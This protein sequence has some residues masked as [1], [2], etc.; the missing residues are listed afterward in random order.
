[1][2]RKYSSIKY[3]SMIFSPAVAA[4]LIPLIFLGMFYFYPV[5]AILIKSFVIASKF[6]MES[7]LIVFESKRILKIIGFTFWQAGLSTLI[8]LVIGLP[9]A[10]VFASYDFKFKKAL[11]ILSTIPFVLP[12]V[13]VAAAFQTLIGENGFIHS[14][15]FE[16]PVLMILMAH[17][18]FN[19]SVVLRIVST[20]WGQ[21]NRQ[22]YDAASILGASPVKIF[23]YITLPMLRPALMAC[24]ILV[25]IFCFCSFGVIMILGGPYYSTME[26][27]IYRQAAHLFNLPVAGALSLI[28]ILVTFSLMWVYTFYF[29]KN[30]Q[31]SPDNFKRK[32]KSPSGY[33][34]KGM[35]YT[36]ILFIVCFCI[37]PMAA[38][39]LKSLIYKNGFSLV[40]YR[41]LFHNATQSFF[42][43]SPVKAIWNSLLFSFTTLIMACVIGLAAAFFIHYSKKKIGA[44]LDPIFMLPLSTSAVTLGFGIILTMDTAW[45]DLRT[46]ILL[47]PIAHTLVA[48]PFVIR[49][50]LP[51]IRSIPEGVKE[52]SFVLGASRF[53]CWWHI[54]MPIILKA[55]LTGAVFAFTISLGEFGAT[56]FTARPEFSTI[57]VAIYKFLGNPGQMNYGQAMAVSSILMVVT[58]VGF[59][60]IEKY[61]NFNQDLF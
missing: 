26:V 40:F 17:V 36:S 11:L 50:V 23:C 29:K 10:Y 25:F 7:F 57:P 42:Y 49:S 5:S 44:I 21:I 15:A 3:S 22:V 52:A 31:F 53:R 58:A 16:H 48:F 13:V 37:F 30:I 47:I 61:S 32:L 54:E 9:C 2:D 19:F 55:L 18:F 46:S 12:T 4:G 14:R 1:M 20:F 27:E 60:F 34:Q 28:Q 38:L 39:F 35:V 59:V 8:T 45:I 51:T 6:S 56:I 24:T 43:I 33:F 41:A